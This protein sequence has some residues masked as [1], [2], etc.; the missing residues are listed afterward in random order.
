MTLIVVKENPLV[1]PWHWLNTG[2][3]KEVN[4]VR[5]KSQNYPEG[6]G[7]SKIK[8]EVLPFLY[9]FFNASVL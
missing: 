5:K 3:S 8:E 6:G 1:G 9:I 4:S 2:A 7:G